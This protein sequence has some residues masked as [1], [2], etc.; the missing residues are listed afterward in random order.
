MKRIQRAVQSGVSR[1]SVS[2]ENGIASSLLTQNTPLG[3]YVGSIDGDILGIFEGAADGN[4]EGPADG[5]TLGVTL[6]D[7]EGHALG[8]YKN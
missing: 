3:P 2:W 6:G 7:N 8:P 4:N 5:H 1:A